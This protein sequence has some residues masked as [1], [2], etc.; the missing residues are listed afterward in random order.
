[1]CNFALFHSNLDNQKNNLGM[2]KGKMILIA[3]LSA[4]LVAC[5]GK[6]NMKMGDNE[7][8]V[9]TISTQVSALQNSY[10]ATIKGMQDI[11]IRPKVQGFIT[12]LCVKEGQSVSA[13]QL[14]FVLDNVTYAEA[15]KQAQAA[16]KS[17]QAQLATARL[18]YNNNVQLHKENVIGDYQLQSAANAL[19][20]ANAALAQARANYLAAKQNLDYCYVKSPSAGVIGDLPYRVGALVSSSS[21]QP[22]TTVSNINT[23][24]VYF[25]MTEKQ[26]LDMTRKSG[27]T[28]KVVAEYPDVKLKLADG[29]EYAYSGH[30]SAVSGVINQTTGS[31]SMRADFTNPQHLLKSGGSGTILVPVVNH[32]AIV[33]PQDAVS[34]VQDKY[35]VYILQSNNKVKYSEITVSET[36]DGQ[37]YVVTTG[38]K[39]GDR[40]AVAG[41][42]ALSDGMEIKPITEAQYAAK[43]KKAEQLGSV[44]NDKDKL[45]KAFGK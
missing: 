43:L 4:V 20:S 36:N 34:Q 19:A 21:A 45:M 16:V 44:Q 37:N 12:K 2:K 32:D 39:V 18:T 5:G 13:G 28:A 30:V 22:L 11:E 29:S 10:P 41:V 8:P 7:Y 42:S 26:L 38:L 33:I 40:I 6:G 31:V 1:M 23:M 24:Y 9:R 3:A 25:S 27:S 14:L 17:A 15:A 35:F